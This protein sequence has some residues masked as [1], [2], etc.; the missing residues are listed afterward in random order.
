MFLFQVPAAVSQTMQWS[1]LCSFF[2]PQKKYRPTKPFKT[3]FLVPV[4]LLTQIR[5]AAD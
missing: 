4:S 2:F 1:I 5:L 3:L